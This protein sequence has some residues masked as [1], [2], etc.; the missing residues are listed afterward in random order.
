MGPL[1]GLKIIEIAGI[2][3]GP[4]CG[5]LFADIGAEVISVEKSTDKTATRLPDCARRGKRS[6]ALNLKS[7]QGV[8]ALL[9][10]IESADAIFEGFRP[11]VMEKLGLG[12]DV[13]MQRNPK[14]VY[15]R[16]TGW[17]QYG[18]LSQAAGHDINYISL[19]GALHAMGRSHEKPV[20]PL[21]LVGDFGGGGMFLAFGM[22]CALLEAQ[23]SA[24]GQVIDAAMTDGSALLMSMFNFLQE[25]G[26]WST[27]R[28]TSFLDSG[29]HFYEVYQT[30]D[31]K[32]ISIGSIE[33]QFYQ[34]LIE[35]AQLDADVFS[36]QNNKKKWPE[37]KLELDTVFKRKTQSLWCELMEGTDVCFAPVLNLNEAQQH[38]HNI[39]RKTYIEVEG[40]M[41]PAPAPRFSRTQPEVKFGARANGEDTETALAQ[42]G[43][44]SQEILELKNSKGLS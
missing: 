11:G 29:A 34:L 33:P 28:G 17:G 24:K 10:L 16:M 9:K 15:G 21:N 6:I 41:Q 5:M 44:S 31:E 26:M 36:Q 2:G 12:P 13:C 37:L 27:E 1:K 22:V 43:F 18:P 8:G 25:V 40:M 4:F 42:W 7:Q 38:P 30:S 39:A 3:P 32:Y 14:L 19:T 20:P 35:K 23:K